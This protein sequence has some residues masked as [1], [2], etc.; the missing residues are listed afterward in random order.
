MQQGL[1]E[2]LYQQVATYAE[3]GGFSQAEKLAAETAERFCWD[4]EAMMSDEDYWARMKE[5]FTD[6]Q[7]LELITLI[8]YCVG[9]GRTLAILDIANDCPI[10]QTPDP[11]EDPSHYVHG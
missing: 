11:A 5:H 10:N 3:S 6:Q 9:I 8:G 1:A 4:H 2:D 7:I